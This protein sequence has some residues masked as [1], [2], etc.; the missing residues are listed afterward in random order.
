[1]N[2]KESRGFEFAVGQLVGEIGGEHREGRIA[3][4]H[5]CY[6]VTFDGDDEETA[7]HEDLLTGL[8]DRMRGEEPCHGA[9]SD[10][11]EG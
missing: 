8:A 1:M 7:I 3:A 9:E 6:I 2:K 5:P 4:R 11:H 10:Q